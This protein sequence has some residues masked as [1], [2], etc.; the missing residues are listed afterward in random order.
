MHA[1][2]GPLNHTAQPG[3]WHCDMDIMHDHIRLQLS[4]GTKAN[5]QIIVCTLF[6]IRDF[7]FLFGITY[8]VK[9]DGSVCFY[10]KE[11]LCGA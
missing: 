9:E 5:M 8:F 1:K 4:A 3:T 2:H 6:G 11:F 10:E 7:L